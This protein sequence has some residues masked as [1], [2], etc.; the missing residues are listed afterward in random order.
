M[1]PDR[2]IYPLKFGNVVFAAQDLPFNSK[3]MIVVKHTWFKVAND[4]AKYTTVL[5][6][7]TIFPRKCGNIVFMS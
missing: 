7:C 4:V 6:D 3:I 2:D 1:L 5:P